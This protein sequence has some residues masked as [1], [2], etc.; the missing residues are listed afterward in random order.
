M[1]TPVRR[2]RRL[3]LLLAV[4]GSMLIA[5]ALIWLF[6]PAAFG[7]LQTPELAAL[8]GLVLLPL[9]TGWAAVSDRRAQRRAG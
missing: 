3:A 5:L 6:A 9:L 8:L 2:F 4:P 7:P 1:P